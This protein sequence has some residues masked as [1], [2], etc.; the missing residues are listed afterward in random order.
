MCIVLSH[1]V[2]KTELYLSINFSFSS[3]TTYKSTVVIDSIG[4]FG[5]ILTIV[6]PSFL[7]K[8]HKNQEILNN[9]I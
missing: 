6:M 1:S 8:R 7:L 5:T 3:L 4:F 9:F 2:I